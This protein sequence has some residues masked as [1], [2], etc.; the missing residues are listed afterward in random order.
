MFCDHCD[1]GYHSYCVGVTRI[2]TGRWECPSCTKDEKSVK[3]EIKEEDK[4]DTKSETGKS[5]TGKSETGKS[6][7]GKSEASEDSSRPRS[8]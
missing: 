3:K 5:E 7:T 6:E 2:P 4:E 8:K 1:R